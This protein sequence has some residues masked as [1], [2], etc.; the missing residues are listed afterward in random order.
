MINLLAASVLNFRDFGNRLQW[1]KRDR[2][3]NNE[4]STVRYQRLTWEH[5]KLKTKRDRSRIKKAT[6]KIV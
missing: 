2:R 5:V 3:V 1:Y 4:S 6:N